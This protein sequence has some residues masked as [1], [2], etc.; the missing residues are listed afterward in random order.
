MKTKICSKCKKELFI[1][2]FSKCKNAIDKLQR[3][4]T[5]C[6]K[7]YYKEYYKSYKKEHSNRMKNWYLKNK[8]KVR[9]QTKKWY[10]LHN[11]EMKNY[12]RSN[13][14]EARKYMKNRLKTDISFKL[15]H[16]LRTRLYK[17]LKNNIKSKSIMKLLGCSIEFLKRHL[18]NQFR[19]R[20][21]WNNYGKWHIDHIRPCASF[22]LSKESEQKK[23][24]NWKNLQ[25]L[26]AKDNLSKKRKLKELCI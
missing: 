26:W 11:K 25:P 9:Q 15:C 6:K 13:K 2:K 23:C 3:W 7:K 22:D 8:D 10:K 21:T 5:K 12:R 19:P 24:F 17:V 16:Y 4:C 1:L 18:E 20:M 14:I